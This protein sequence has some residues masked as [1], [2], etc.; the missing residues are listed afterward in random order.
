MPERIVVDPAAL[1]V[2]LDRLTH[3][4]GELAAVAIRDID[5]L[6]GSALGN[7]GEPARVTADVHRL[8]TTLRDWVC[9][10]RRSV[11]ELGAADDVT[12]EQL[13]QP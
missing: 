5:G 11:S 9:S 13:Q 8:E 6:P 4:A 7:S 1:G 12:A 2:L 10:V 3:A